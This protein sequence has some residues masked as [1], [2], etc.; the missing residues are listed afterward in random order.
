VVVCDIQY[1]NVVVCDIWHI[2]VVVY[3]IRYINVVVVCFIMYEYTI[4][5]LILSWAVCD[6]RVF[7]ISYVCE[8]GNNK[9]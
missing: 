8:K 4:I 1:M 6:V 5:K 3:D 7:C 9:L 2:D